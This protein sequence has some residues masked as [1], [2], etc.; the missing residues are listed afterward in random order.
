MIRRLTPR[1]LLPTA[2]T[3]AAII[4]QPCAASSPDGRQIASGGG[5]GT[6][7]TACHGVDGAGN[8]ATGFPRLAGLNADYLRHQLDA[9]ADGTRQNAVMTPVAKALCVDQRKAVAAFYAGL[10]WKATAQSDAAKPDALG[11]KIA[12]QGRASKDVES[13]L[14]ACDACHGPGG[15]GVGASFPALAGQPRRYLEGQL[16]AWQQ[17]TRPSGTLGVMASVA[18]RL[19]DEELAAVSR[20]FASL[21]PRSTGAAP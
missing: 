16:R 15:T 19:S 8:G 21:T 10:P 11:Q 13:S 20:Y 18:K 2:L 9:F 14:P 12:Q 3:A 5:D 7:C 1:T 6:A 4:L 17:G